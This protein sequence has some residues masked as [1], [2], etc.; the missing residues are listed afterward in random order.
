MG[1][2]REPWI[3]LRLGLR[4]SDKLSRLRS[5]SARLGYIYLLLEAKV[6][7]RPG[8]FASPAHLAELLGRFASYIDAY[9]EVGLLHRAPALCPS[10][11]DRHEGAVAPELVVHDFAKDQRDP[12]NADRQDAFRNARR[13]AT[14]NAEGNG[15]LTRARNDGD[16]D[17][18]Y[19]RSSYGG[20]GS[21]P[22]N[23]PLTPIGD[24]L[25]TAPR[26]AT[27]TDPGSES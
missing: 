6:Q 17:S 21:S 8:V 25:M 13:N 5:D 22:R 18:D 2:P 20:S 12:S 19:E 11:A 10:C 7:R 15:L 26:A 24:I 16:G 4:R 3:K 9:I 27:T 1:S 14:N 23:R